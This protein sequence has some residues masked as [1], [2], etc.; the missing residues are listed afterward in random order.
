MLKSVP[1]PPAKVTSSKKLVKTENSSPKKVKE[2]AEVDK[3]VTGKKRT[4]RSSDTVDNRSP[5]SGIVI[6]KLKKDTSGCISEVETD[7]QVKG[8][9][10]TK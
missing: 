1:K 2:A 7:K 8:D 5:I 3:S 6:K 9:I 4:V 10:D